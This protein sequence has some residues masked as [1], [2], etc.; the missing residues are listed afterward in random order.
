MGAVADQPAAQGN[1][2]PGPGAGS[3]TPRGQAP[4][5]KV[6]RWASPTCQRY[7]SCGSRSQGARRLSSCFRLLSGRQRTERARRG[8]SASITHR[9]ARHLEGAHDEHPLDSKPRRRRRLDRRH[10]DAA[11]GLLRADDATG[12]GPR[13]RSGGHRS[14]T[15]NRST[16][17]RC[18]YAAA[19]CRRSLRW[20][21][22]PVGCPLR[23][24]GSRRDRLRSSPQ[25]AAL[26]WPWSK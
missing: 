5:P 15:L 22:P 21:A 11:L 1:G 23:A 18:R 16:G 10:L 25:A 6:R 9:P 12:F 14:G 13:A 2:K 20:P 8:D 17:S 24:D 3:P 4:P 19:R 26:R 7:R